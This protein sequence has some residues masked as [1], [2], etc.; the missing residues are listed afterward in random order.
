[1]ALWGVYIAWC[2]GEGLVAPTSQCSPSLA[3]LSTNCWKPDKEM[4]KFCYREERCIIKDRSRDGLLS[5]WGCGAHSPQHPRLM[6]MALYSVLTMYYM[7][8]PLYEVYMQWCVDVLIA[9][10]V[11]WGRI[12]GLHIVVPSSRMDPGWPDPRAGGCG[13]CGPSTCS[14]SPKVVSFI[15]SPNYILYAYGLV[16]GVCIA[17]CVAKELVAPVSQCSPAWLTWAPYIER[18][19]AKRWMSTIDPGTACTRS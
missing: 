9:W 11:C 5:S 17:S 14:W 19:T 4:L 6:L 12:G 8:M 15:F 10:C 3:H 16:W 1:M 18:L 7:H 13:I 2:A